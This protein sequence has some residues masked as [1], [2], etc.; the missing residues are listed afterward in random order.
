MT[1]AE[2]MDALL[3]NVRAKARDVL[4]EGIGIIILLVDADANQL[5]CVSNMDSESSRRV[6][7]KALERETKNG[8]VS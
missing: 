5:G 7:M 4:P 1:N 2:K 6:L 8:S 3:D